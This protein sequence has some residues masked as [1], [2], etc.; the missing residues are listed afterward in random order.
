MGNTASRRVAPSASPPQPVIPYEIRVQHIANK[1]GWTRYE[2]SMDS[3]CSFYYDARTKYLW[4]VQQIGVETPLIT[5]PSTS[6][7][8]MVE[9]NHGI[10][11]AYDEQP[12]LFYG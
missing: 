9:K 5:R 4:V 10:E 1:H 12:P 2:T 11:V 6:H 7:V 8:R 3:F